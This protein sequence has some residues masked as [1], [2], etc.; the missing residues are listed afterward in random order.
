MLKNLSINLRCTLGALTFL[1]IALSSFAQAQVTVSGLVKSASDQEALPGVSV[2]VKGTQTGTVTD[3][4]GRYSIK[5]PQLGATLVFTFIGFT[6]Q[7]LSASTQILNVDL[8]EDNKTLGEVVVVGYGTMRKQDLTGAV[9]VVG[10][11][12]FQKGTITTPEQLISG[13]V[14]G[15]SI[16][17]GGGQ[18]GSGSTIRIR[19]GAS[20]SASNDPLFVIDDVP[21]ENSQVS[22]ASNPLSF[23]NPNDIESFTVLKDASATAI[24]GAR[25]SNGVIIIT[26]K[27]GTSGKLNV[28]FSTVNALSTIEKYADV[29]S[30]EQFK[31]VVNQFGTADQKAAVGQFDTDWQKQIYQNGFNTDNNISFDGGIKKLPYRLSLG[32]QDQS[33]ILKTDKYQKTSAALALNPSFLDE[34]LKVNLNIKGSMQKT[35]FANQ[36]AI[37]GAVSFDPSQAVYTNQAKYGGYWEYLNATNPSGLENLVGR[38]P[39]GLLNQREDRATPYRSIGNLSLSYKFHFLPDLKAVLNLGYDASTGK[40]TV[41]V[42]ATAAELIDQGGTDS[43]YKQNKLNTVADF[44]LNYVKDIKSIKSRV[45]ATAGYSYNDYLTKVFNYT[46][47]NATGAIISEPAFPYDEPRARTRSYFARFNYNYDERYF[48]TGT[49]RTDGSSRFAEEN[50]YGTFPSV[51]LSWAINNESFLKNNNT[52][53]LLKLRASY[54]LTGQQ[55]INSLFGYMSYYNLSANTATYQFGDTYYQMYRP[56]GYISD[57]K[58][59][60]TATSNIALDFGLYNNRISGSIDFYKRKTSDLLN[61][62]PQPAGTNFS[63]TAFVN[64]GDMENKGV[65]LSLNVVPVQNSNF[66]WDA[67]F[68]LTHNKNIITNL[69]VVPQDPNYLGF[70]SGTIAGGV[71]GQYAFINAVGYPKN[72]FFL[73]KQVYDASGKPLEGIYL[74]YD[75]DG[76][77]STSDF[78][79]GE[80]ADPNVFLGFTNNLS[81]KKWSSSFVLRASLGNYVYNNAFSQRGNLAQ[82]VGN[83]VLLNGSTNFFDTGFKN[84]QLLSDYYVENGSFLKMDN[85]SVGYNFGK[86][87]KNG[88]SLKASAFVQNVFTITKY[89]GMDPEV[90]SGVD[91]NIYP[92]PRIFS[93]GLNLSL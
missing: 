74:D 23:I 22:G 28:N 4:Q 14:P 41:Y 51:A 78:V 47:Y 77:I 70:P 71:S 55:D 79:K 36:A 63:A 76:A 39:L 9:T 93:L 84:Q 27:K 92:R 25:A 38:N 20:L 52:I 11:K 59:E 66:R 80:T 35:R 3:A 8:K 7:E 40:G 65:E 13:K 72:T 82:F 60:Q 68:N 90:A 12:D 33:G 58:W 26:T 16:V 57:L 62:I 32:F 5:V 24:Y 86:I 75:K 49:V 89:K 50:R 64:V 91:N 48:I 34:H 87:A 69:T 42:P 37:G 1:M 10:A 53:N 19:G 21:L 30:T 67:G 61:K 73:Y 56:S 83:Q 81:Y 15:V 6:T 31:S 44:Y 17:S 2:S 46:S 18:P 29:L 45:E 88:A 85:F 54:G 43:K